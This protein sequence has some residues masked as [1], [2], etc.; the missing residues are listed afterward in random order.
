[1]T[2]QRLPTPDIVKLAGGPSVIARAIRRDHSTVVGWK[3]IPAGHA[4]KVAALAG[5]HPSDVRPDVYDQHAP[6][7]GDGDL[8]AAETSGLIEALRERGLTQ[9]DLAARAG[10]SAGAV[11]R[12][13]SRQRA[14]PVKTATLLH[15]ELGI[16][17]SVLRPDICNPPGDR[18]AVAEESGAADPPAP[19][20]P[21]REAGTG[22][23]RDEFGLDG[24]ARLRRWALEQVLARSPAL[25][26]LTPAA[27]DLAREGKARTVVEAADVLARFVLR[28]LSSESP[29]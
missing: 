18:F 1:M 21:D 17:L 2:Q 9:R 24:E 14:V 6:A 23:G 11:S 15:R 12:W 28:G 26:F 4:R 7:S 3:R 25:G 20:G 5:L 8:G 29:P 19:P 22:G 16:P 10:V 13:C 27:A